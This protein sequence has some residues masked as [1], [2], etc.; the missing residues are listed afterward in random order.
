MKHCVV[1]TLTDPRDSLVKYVGIT[2]D[3]KNRFSKH[4]SDKQS[5]EGILKKN[6]VLKLLKLGLEPI[7]DVIDEGD[8]DYCQKAE[9]SYI[10]LYRACGAKLKNQMKTG[11][12]FQHTDE[13]KRKISEAKKGKPLTQKQIEANKIRKHSKYWLGKTFS[14]EH[15]ENISK[16][17]KGIVAKNATKTKYSE[18]I[19]N[20]LKKEYAQGGISQLGL[21]K[22]YNI[23]KSTID[24]YLKR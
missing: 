11:F 20:Q 7:I 21:A 15:I 23:T 9:T 18:E 10:K 16:N 19:I 3:V 6:W 22:K 14:K 2:T 8:V 24:R 17:R 13:T 1:Y 5:K 12:L 4:K